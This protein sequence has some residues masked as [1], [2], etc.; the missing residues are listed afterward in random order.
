MKMLVF[1]VQLIIFA[2]ESAPSGCSS[3]LGHELSMN[4]L[5]NPFTELDLH[6][7]WLRNTCWKKEVF[8][9]C[10]SI[11]PLHITQLHAGYV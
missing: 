3:S 9:A 2:V 5:W 10:L 8:L 1:N 11:K 4:V 7:C 6:S